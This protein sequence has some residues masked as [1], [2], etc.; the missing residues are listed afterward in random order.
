[1]AISCGKADWMARDCERKPIK[2]DLGQADLVD[3]GGLRLATDPLPQG[4]LYPLATTSPSEGYCV[5]LIT[6]EQCA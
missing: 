2:G 5:Q 3:F 4:G 1:M 6:S